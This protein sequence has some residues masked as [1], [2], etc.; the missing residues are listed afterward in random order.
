M[1][2]SPTGDAM[3]MRYSEA[4]AETCKALKAITFYPPNHP[5][6]EKILHNAYQA[7]ADLLKQDGVSL[8]VQRNG[9]SL[10]NHE[11]VIENTPM[12]RALAKE[13]FTREIQL[14]T[15][16][17][18][19]SRE[20]FFK[21]LSL[22]A[23]DSIK[24]I[25]EGG[26]AGMLAKQGIQSVICNKID[27]TEVFTRK[28][29]GEASEHSVAEGT[30]LQEESAESTPRPEDTLSDPLNDLSIEELLALMDAETDDRHY[31]QLARFL[32]AKGQELKVEVDFNRLFPILLG[33]LDQIS[34]VTMSAARHDCAN[35][36]FQHLAQ[37][38]MVE[39]LLD[40]LEDKEFAQQEFVHLIFKQLG[41]DV[42]TAVISRF[43]AVDNEFSRNALAAAILR[44]GLPAVP[45]L[46]DMLKDSRWQVVRSVIG[47][48]GDMKSTDS[49]T[50]LTRTAFHVDTRLR[51]ESVSSLAKIG[52]KEATSVLVD[53]LQDDNPA[54]RLQAVAWIGHTRNKRGLHPLI[55]LLNKRDVLGKM[56]NFKKEILLAIGRIGDQ[57]ALEPLFKMVKKRHW[58]VPSRHEELKFLAI[59]TIGRIGGESAKGFL[60]KLAARNGHIGRACSATLETMG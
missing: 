8:I 4:L 36:V 60:K 18:Q 59:A 15:L 48:L 40:H 6:R 21:F 13:L 56:L 3:T 29:L 1:T 42:V 7:M 12:I 33:L 57:Q 35:M 27:V 20:D 9:L 34:D 26:L 5:L 2:I 11:D 53:L 31:R 51:L 45:A 23:I 10:A 52:G 49:V 22:L 17:P 50:G 25:D 30:V 38:E 54:I 16:Q 55:Q 24:V 37:G 28:R 47:I 41:S 19:L 43:V 39:H 44:I 14:L 58:I 46:N 32:L